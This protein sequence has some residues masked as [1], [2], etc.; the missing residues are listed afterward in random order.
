MC[1]FGFCLCESRY[2][3]NYAGVYKPAFFPL[4]MCF[5]ISGKGHAFVIILLSLEFTH[6]P[7]PEDRVV[8]SFYYDLFPMK[9]VSRLIAR[10]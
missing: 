4:Q 1:C 7:G 3:I 9:W 8:I 5:G 2:I 6:V 10:F